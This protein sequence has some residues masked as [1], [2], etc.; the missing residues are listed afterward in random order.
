MILTLEQSVKEVMFIKKE[1]IN[2]N[3]RT[4]NDKW[5]W[6]DDVSIALGWIVDEAAC[7]GSSARNGSHFHLLNKKEKTPSDEYPWS[8]V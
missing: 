6:V 2:L 7:Q 1:K 5:Y 4:N 8:L 3:E